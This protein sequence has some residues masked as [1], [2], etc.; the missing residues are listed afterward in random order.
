MD[1]QC[2]GSA[3]AISIFEAALISHQFGRREVQPQ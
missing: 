2:G 3:E 1:I